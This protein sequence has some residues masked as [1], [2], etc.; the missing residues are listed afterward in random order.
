[1]VFRVFIKQKGPSYSLLFLELVETFK[2]IL[3]ELLHSQG[4]GDPESWTPL[5]NSHTKVQAHLFHQQEWQGWA[6]GPSPISL[7]VTDIAGR[8][9]QK[10]L[11]LCQHWPVKSVLSWVERVVKFKPACRLHTTRSH[12]YKCLSC[13][14]SG[15][16][17]TSVQE[18][19]VWSLG[20][21]DPLEKETLPLQYSCLENSINREACWATVHGVAKGQTRLSN[22]ITFHFCCATCLV[23]LSSPTRDWTHAPA[24]EAWSPNHW[25]TR[26]FPMS[27]S[28]DCSQKNWTSLRAPYCVVRIEEKWYFELHQCFP[29]QF[30]LQLMNLASFST[31]FS[32]S[33]I[34][35]GFVWRLC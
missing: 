14:L 32:F 27:L 7:I 30:L 9:R 10:E 12:F 33:S 20:E 13:W 16:E 34:Y 18:I 1:M 19:W 6:R 25:T 3:F 29:P 26:E 28:F 31:R 8:S 11:H 5:P 15:R 4:N 17:S 35:Q 21:E 2:D 23:D 22:T 24:V